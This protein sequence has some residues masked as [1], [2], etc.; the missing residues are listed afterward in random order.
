MALVFPKTPSTY[1]QF[2]K[3]FADKHVNIRNDDKVRCNFSIISLESYMKGFSDNDVKEFFDKLRTGAKLTQ[4]PTE[5]NCA[6]ALIQMDGDTDRAQFKTSQRTINASFA[7][8][9]TPKS[10]TWD[11]RDA[12][13]DICYSTGMDIMGAV[14]E[15]FAVNYT[16]G[17]IL[18]ISDEGIRIPAMDL[19]GWRF[20]IEYQVLS[21]YCFKPGKFNG[22]TI[23]EQI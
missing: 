3:E 1:K 10:K 17:I 15:F 14:K 2:F 18:E 12:A 11:D 6:M 16:K 7:I 19:V 22:L 8:L 4:K 13:V 9:T 23:N 20:D 5:N 21:G